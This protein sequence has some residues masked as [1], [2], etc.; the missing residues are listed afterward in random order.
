MYP[1]V[2]VPLFAV[3]TTSEDAEVPVLNDKELFQ[4]TKVMVQVTGFQQGDDVTKLYFS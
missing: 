4:L 2:S 3:A 1:V